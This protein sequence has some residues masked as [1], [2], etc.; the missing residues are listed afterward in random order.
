MP[1][2]GIV[3]GVIAA[4]Y[5]SGE[6]QPLTTNGYLNI[7]TCLFQPLDIVREKMEVLDGTHES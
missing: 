1:D 7:E 6:S 5:L 2:G 4:K 3:S